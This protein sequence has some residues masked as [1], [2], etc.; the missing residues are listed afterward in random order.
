MEIVDNMYGLLEFRNILRLAL[1]LFRIMQIF[2]C[3]NVT[4]LLRICVL[5]YS[6]R[7]KTCHIITRASRSTKTWTVCQTNC[8][9]SIRANL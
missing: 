4:T 6:T 1:M 5:R 7:Q 3:C 9:L 8:R 2:V